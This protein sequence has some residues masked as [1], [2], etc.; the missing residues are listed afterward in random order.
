LGTVATSS[1]GQWGILPDIHEHILTW[2][3][4]V[5][6]AK[7]GGF[8]L[9]CGGKGTVLITRDGGKTWQPLEKEK[10]IQAAAGNG[11]AT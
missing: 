4:D 11:K 1:T 2:I 10:L 8:G 9:A 3:R 6:F 7:T 5:S